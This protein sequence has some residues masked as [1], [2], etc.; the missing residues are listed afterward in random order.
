MFE[1]KHVRSLE[2]LVQA[3]AVAEDNNWPKQKFR[4]LLNTGSNY[5]LMS[6][7]GEALHYYLKAYEIAI[8]DLET[9]DELTV[10]NNIG[11]LY[12]QEANLSKAK[13]YFG[14]AYEL[15]FDSENSSKHGY[16][17]INLAL[18]SNKMQQVEQASKYINEALPLVKDQ[19][20]IEIMAKMALAENLFIKGKYREARE[21][22]LALLSQM[23]GETHTDNRVFMLLLLSKIYKEEK[24]YNLAL[25]NAKMARAASGILEHREDVYEA[26]SN[27]YGSLRE[28]DKAL[29][30][31]DSILIA[32]DSL[33]EKRNNALYENN[34]I[35]FELQKFAHELNESRLLL[36]KERRF[37]YSI[38]IFGMLLL[39]LLLWIFRIHLIRHKQRKK[40]TE[41]ELEQEKTKRLVAEKQMREQ[42]AIVKLEQERLKNELDLKN[43]ELTTRAMYLASKNELI[44]EVI[45]SLSQNLQ[46]AINPSLKNQIND[47][48]KH[49]RKDTQ[50][51]SFFVH[52][53]ELN[54][55][56]LDRL[57]SRHSQLSA[58]DIRFL[59]FLYMNLSYKEIAALLNITPQSCRKRKERISKKMNVPDNL[60]LHAYLAAI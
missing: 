24:Q 42:E 3:T 40:I 22:S 23:A 2:L 52:F 7:F 25:Q 28:Y 44:E 4:A 18:V 30:Y 9:K 48:K 35:K 19:P 53:E 33:Q 26:L 27:A 49:L 31:K 39:V 5:Y 14:K 46:I 55:G 56:F 6:D 58:N 43:R 59:T 17:A 12:F 20:E 37:F 38:V 21:L 34:K 60:P 41:L 57:R 11:I 45:H 8:T 16:Y 32:R 50:W 51:D 10:L 13:E 47:L 36:Q 29:L 54:Q 15:S 1:K